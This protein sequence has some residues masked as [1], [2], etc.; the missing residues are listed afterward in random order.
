MKYI[1]F[2]FLLFGFCVKKIDVLDWDKP[3]IER[4]HNT[5]WKINQER[6]NNIIE[7]HDSKLKLG[8]GN[9]LATSLTEYQI[10]A[11]NTNFVLLS[12][13]ND[14]SPRLLGVKLVDPQTLLVS[15]WTA[16]VQLT[17]QIAQEQLEEQGQLFKLQK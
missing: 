2:L 4:L 6:K 8:V 11:Q 3:L 10:V 5:K 13:Y 9:I 1:I 17:S 16:D 15:I 14:I 7:F 12:I